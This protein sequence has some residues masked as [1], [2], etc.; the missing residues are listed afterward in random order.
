MTTLPKH[1]RPRYRYFAL[2]LETWPSTT[3]DQRAFQS[4]VWHAARRL[5][6]D[7]GSATVGLRVIRFDWHDTTGTAIIRTNHDSV[8]PARAALACVHAVND[9][10]LGLTIRGQSGTIRA[11]E[12]N[13]LRQRPEPVTERTVV[14]EDANRTAFIRGDRVDVAQNN[15]FTGATILDLESD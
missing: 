3:L 6:G 2:H 13:Y 4:A 10:P 15:A 1:L 12:E 9:T 14:F 7:T 5:L 11:C 8:T